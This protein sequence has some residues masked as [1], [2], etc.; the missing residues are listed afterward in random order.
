M[1]WL[2]DPTLGLVKSARPGQLRMAEIIQ[3]VLD[4]PEAEQPARAIIEA[5]T[6]VGKSFGY[7]VPLFAHPG[8]KRVIV[9]T[10]K[11]ALQA[12][13]AADLPKL[14]EVVQARRCAKRLGKS[15]YLCRL[16]LNDYLTSP[17][18]LTRFSVDELEAY[19]KWAG[20]TR[21]G[22]LSEFQGNFD[23]GHLFAKTRV[24]ECIGRQCGMRSQCGFLAMKEVSKTA[25]VLLVNHALLATDFALGRGTVLGEYDALVIDEAH[26]APEAFRSAYTVV[27][28]PWQPKFLES[29]LVCIK[30]FVFPKTLHRQYD[31]L[32]TL[33]S[34]LREGRLDLHNNVA[35]VELLSAIEQNLLRIKA[36][37]IS[38]KLWSDD[39]GEGEDTDELSP[40]EAV[41]KA[42][43]TSVATL[44][45]RLLTFT[46][47][48]QRDPHIVYDVLTGEPLDAG[49]P[50]RATG[51]EYISY[52]QRNGENNEVHTGPVEVG[53]LVSGALLSVPK[54]IITSA[55][56]STGEN[57]DYTLRQYGLPR[58]K[59]SITERVPSPFDYANRSLLHVD[60]RGI[61]KPGY[62]PE[63]S[64]EDRKEKN[65]EY[66]ATQAGLMHEY[67]DASEGGAFILLASREDLVAYQDAF[68]RVPPGT[69]EV[70]FQR[71]SEDGSVAWFKSNPHRVLFGLKSL[72]EGVDVPGLGLRM[73]IVPRLPFPNKSDVVLAARKNRY[74]ARLAANTDKPSRNPGYQS[75]QAFDINIVAQELA[76]GFGRL[77]RRESDLGIGVCTDPRLLTKAYS[78]L[79][80]SNI[81][82]PLERDRECVIETAKSIAVTAKRMHARVLAGR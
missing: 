14:R 79:L 11:K 29:G 75:F 82:L 4:T 2:Q 3:G 78:P 61:E 57:F 22:E 56:L 80:R 44:V 17:G 41:L 62:S 49:D 71:S 33:V 45:K 63:D 18:A 51:V 7:L 43:V 24:A 59:I 50:A 73:V 39:A 6:G 69:Y 42:K 55:T 81:P 36:G 60:M 19:S 30:D 16:H 27:L 37:L 47:I 10:G 31:A 21:F 72:W 48:N 23:T 76:Q 25:E 65:I 38:R 34:R 77:I 54:L 66:Y 53:P 68:N 20:E 74:E 64:A 46:A 70:G 28:A 13:L 1:R 5:G 8:V 12:Q 40:D 15:N 52:A 58:A 67:L 26:A 9:S 35:A 32:M